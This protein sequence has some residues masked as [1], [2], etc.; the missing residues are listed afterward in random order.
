L[1]RMEKINAKSL[2]KSIKLASETKGSRFNSNIF[3]IHF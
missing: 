3:K 2:L 1:S